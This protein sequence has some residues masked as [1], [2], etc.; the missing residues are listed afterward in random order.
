MD[1]STGASENKGLRV[2]FG[3]GPCQTFVTVPG[4]VSRRLSD[5]LYDAVI[6]S[7]TVFDSEVMS[8]CRCSAVYRM[9]RQGIELER[10]YEK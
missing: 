10:F 7:G 3:G 1:N 5:E 8:R 6:A 9:N 2:P 4:Y